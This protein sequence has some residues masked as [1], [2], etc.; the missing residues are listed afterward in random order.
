M[1]NFIALA[2]LLLSL[3]LAACGGSGDDRKLS[4]LTAEDAKEICEEQPEP[5]DA[6]LKGLATYLCHGSLEN[7]CTEANLDACVS[8]AL[9]SVSEPEPCEA[10]TAEEL[11]DLKNCDVTVDQWFDCQKA[12]LDSYKGFSSL[13]CDDNPSEPTRPTK[14]DVIVSKCPQLL[15]GEDE[16]N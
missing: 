8:Q 1:K 3:T 9:G 15:G 11:A 14:C 5:S 16:V 13:A 6:Q 12:I 4:E 10:P 2:A 7:E